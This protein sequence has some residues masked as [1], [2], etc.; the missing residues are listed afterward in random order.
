MPDPL[1]FRAFDIDIGLLLRSR[2]EPSGLSLDHVLYIILL[3]LVIPS[4]PVFQLLH[5]QR[6]VITLLTDITKLHV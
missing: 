1:S 5:R 2:L 4:Q 6:Y 3:E